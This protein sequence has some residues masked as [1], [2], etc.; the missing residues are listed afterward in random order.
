[1]RILCVPLS[2]C[3]KIF[4]SPTP[5][6]FHSFSSPLVS[7][8]YSLARLFGFT[9]YNEKNYHVTDHLQSEFNFKLNISRGKYT[10]SFRRAS[11]FSSSDLTSTLGR[12]TSGSK[13]ISG[14]TGA[15]SDTCLEFHLLSIEALTHFKM[16]VVKRGK[17]KTTFSLLMVHCRGQD[18]QDITRFNKPVSNPWILRKENY[19]ALS[20]NSKLRNVILRINFYASI[21]PVAWYRGLESF[22][23]REICAPRSPQSSEPRGKRTPWT[24]WFTKSLLLLPSCM[25]GE[26][27][28]ANKSYI[29]W[30][31]KGHS[32]SR[33]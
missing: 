24:P 31:W 1:M 13:W 3:F 22:R 11:S 17:Y 5:L 18:D 25:V 23:W 15:S 6:S 26:Y 12:L 28:I 21:W 9:K 14:L 2:P 10:Y 19:F 7:N 30:Y 4:T 8:R 29:F 33:M 32:S 16:N 20:P 27:K